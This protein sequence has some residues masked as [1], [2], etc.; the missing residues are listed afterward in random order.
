MKKVVT[1][2]LDEVLRPFRGRVL[3]RLLLPPL[4]SMLCCKADSES[5]G[6]FLFD[7]GSTMDLFALPLCLDHVAKSVPVL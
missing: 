7:R 4:H 1:S 3:L 5:R 6:F 2:G